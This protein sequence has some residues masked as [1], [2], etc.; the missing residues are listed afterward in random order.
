MTPSSFTITGWILVIFG[1]TSLH[2]DAGDG[3]WRNKF[4]PFAYMLC[5]SEAKESFSRFFEVMKKATRLHFGCD[6]IP[7]FITQDHSAAIAAAARSAWSSI[8][9][10]LCWVHVLRK[11]RDNRAKVG[12]SRLNARVF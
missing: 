5:E 10:L 8:C 11:A 2:F 9:I 7:A 4:V 12:H 1:T 6:L 3:V